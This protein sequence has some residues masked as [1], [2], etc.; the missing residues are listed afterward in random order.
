MAKDTTRKNATQKAPLPPRN[1]QSS[2]ADGRGDGPARTSRKTGKKA[3]MAEADAPPDTRTK[4]ATKT[5]IKP[6]NKKAPVMAKPEKPARVKEAA[7]AAEPAGTAATAETDSGAVRVRMYRQGLGDCFLLAFPR[8]EGGEFFVLIDCGVILGTPDGDQIMKE[9]VADIANE[10]GGTLDVLVATHEHWDHVSGFVQA[11]DEFAKFKTIREVWLAWTED[12]RNETA[13]RIRR[14]REARLDALKKGLVGLTQKLRA[15]DPDETGPQGKALATL[16][17]AAEVLT[18]FGIDPAG[19]A[20]GDGLGASAKD[21]G[22]TTSAAMKWL[23]ERTEKPRYWKPGQSH[24]V[25]IQGGSLRVYVLGPPEDKL[26]MKDLPT[27]SGQETYHELAHF[28]A[29]AS[30]FNAALDGLSAFKPTIPFDLKYQ[31]SE[32]D[33]RRVE[34]FREQYFGTDGEDDP[35]AWRRIDAAWAAGA[36]EFALKLDSDTNNTSLALAFELPDGRVLLFPGDAQV[37]NWESWHAD[38]SGNKRVWKVKERDDE[39]V[40]VTA[41]MLLRNTV[42]Y[43]AG[44]HGSH[45]ATLRGQGLELMTHEDLVAMVPVDTYIAHEKKHWEKMP[46]LPLM[47]RL[48]TLAKDRVIQADQTRERL[49]AT[50]PTAPEKTALKD[51][52]RDVV[53]A[54]TAF[55]TQFLEE[56]KGKEKKV[57][58]PLYVEY[59]IKL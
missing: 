12:P 57:D 58:R 24:E 6:R 22:L 51:F 41:E 20:V 7:A 30:T 15:R 25:K 17:R 39:I 49:T 8:P 47:S 5:K 1:H 35:D 16:D 28:A 23:R 44:H 40:E 2:R 56:E 46:F 53:D 38:A 11:R 48:K 9:V 36:T 55:K 26:L 42:L 13:N 21:D 43:K 27:R 29:Y 32:D 54:P 10:T 3:S 4:S 14:D 31:I 19:A 34:F 37:G 59:C 45:N 18:F 33:A 52:L 50:V